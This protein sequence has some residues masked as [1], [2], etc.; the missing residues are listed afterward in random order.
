LNN[1]KDPIH[2][3]Y[4]K[5]DQYWKSVTAAYNSAVPK[6]KARQLKQVKDHF[7][8]IKKRVAWFCASWKEANAMWASGESDV[9]LMDRAVKLYED[10]HKNDGPFMFKHCWE[11]LCKEPK[12][13]CLYRTS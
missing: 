12:W 3:N 11:V 10:E 13:G 4:K 8:R 5:N 6:S 2:S 1:S 7:G 9:N